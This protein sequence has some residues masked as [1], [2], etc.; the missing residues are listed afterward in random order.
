M[1]TV[2]RILAV[3]LGVAALLVL[4][5]AACRQQSPGWDA[6]SSVPMSPSGNTD[7]PEAIKTVLDAVP[8]RAMQ[9]SG[10]AGAM[11]GVNLKAHQVGTYDVLLPL[12]QLADGQAPVFYSLGAKPKAALAACRLQERSDGNAFVNLTLNVSKGQEVAIEWSSV[13]LIAG[14]PLLENRTAPEMFRAATACAQADDSQIIELAGRLWPATGVAQDYAANIQ[15][16]IRAV[17]PQK[18]PMSLDALGILATGQNTICTANANLACALMRARQVA[19][20]SIA[21]LP[22]LSRRFEMHRIVEYCDDG[23]WIPFDPSGVYSAIPL[24]PY[25]NIIMVKTSISDEQTSMK[26][27]LGVMRGCPFGQEVEFARPGLSLFGQAFF[28]TV[29]A[30]LAEFDVT[31]EAFTLTAGVWE[32]YLMTGTTSA[33]QSKAASARDLG[34]Y[35]EAMRTQ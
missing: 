34:Q 30:P 18:R 27:R 22:T 20:R 35:L 25:Q 3:R 11:G 14:K 5:A 28:W 9:G 23:T 31:D 19:C 10:L 33:A 16:F 8:P 17:E 2:P 32:R 12:P 26:P 13:L 4:M 1:K 6:A 7:I 29:A 21:T 15:E 24:E